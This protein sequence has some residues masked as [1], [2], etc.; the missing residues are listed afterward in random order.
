MSWARVALSVVLGASLACGVETDFQDAEVPT[1]E[2]RPERPGTK[3]VYEPARGCENGS[4]GFVYRALL[5]IQGRAAK[6]VVEQQLLAEAVDALD[7]NGLDGRRIVARSLMQM[8]AGADPRYLRHWHTILEE[9]LELPRV[10]GQ[11]MPPCHATRFAAAH[12]TQL[13]Q[14]VAT[15]DPMLAFGQPWGLGDLIESSL[16]YDDIRAVFL[17]RLL[18]RVATPVSG[19]NVSPTALE[20]AQRTNWGR[21]FEGVFLGR[22]TECLACHR[23]DFSVTDAADPASDRFWPLAD[24]ANPVFEQ[25]S[26]AE[27]H[28]GFRNAGF[29]EGSIPPWGADTCGG[30]TPGTNGDILEIPGFLAGP[31]PTGA[32]ALEIVARLQRGFLALE[33]LV[34]T[35]GTEWTDASTSIPREAALAALVAANFAD[36]VWGT[37]AG[38][39]LT[40]RHGFPRNQ[41]QREA[42]LHLTSTFVNTGYSLRELLVEVVVHPALNQAPSGSCQTDVDPTKDPATPLPALLDPYSRD[43]DPLHPGNGIG[44]GVVRH[45]AYALLDRVAVAMGWPTAKRHPFPYTWEDEDL[46]QALGVHLE[47]TRPGHR[48]ADWIGGLVWEDRLA[49]GQDPGF[50]GSIVDPPDADTVDRILNVAYAD[51]HAT[52]RETWQTLRDRLLVSPTLLNGEAALLEELT[53][54]EADTP[55]AAIPREQLEAGLRASVGAWIA[56]PQFM[57]AG[58]SPQPGQKPPRLLLAD[59]SREV[60]CAYYLPRLNQQLPEGTGFRCDPGGFLRLVRQ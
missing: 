12:N 11:S 9:L 4:E 52:V 29:G 51:S 24:L 8:P 54:L 10:G 13:A 43:Y 36:G 60:L 26:E 17:G 40:L 39:R 49:H 38:K 18:T 53:G 14:F 57:L 34:E 32:S 30:L 45:R 28:A 55:V 22:R 3:Q 58:M 15:N 5:R 23:A 44:D 20:H 2:D 46:Y 56:T 33:Q 59:S 50:S 19:N 47:S 27:I 21:S 31:L 42:L 7:T 48:E 1:A 41:A 35:Q 6:S 37:V 16:R 25:H